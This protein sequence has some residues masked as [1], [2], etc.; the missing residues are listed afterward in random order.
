MLKLL[1]KFVIYIGIYFVSFGPGYSY[2][3][4]ELLYS[5]VYSQT[6]A[7]FVLSIYCF[8]VLCMAVNGITESFV[9]AVASESEM[10]Y[11][12]IVMLLFS[13]VYLMVAYL[14][15]QY[16]STPGLVIA[17]CLN[18]IF[19]IIFNGRYILK[20]YS[21]AK[22]KPSTISIYPHYQVLFSFIIIF[23]SGLASSNYWCNATYSIN[24]IIIFQFFPQGCIYHVLIGLAL[25]IT[26]SLQIYITEKQFIR[27]IYTIWKTK[28]Q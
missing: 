20:Q 1:L 16:F 24:D 3:L 21:Q 7:P 23:L 19:R 15:I 4:L 5:Q 8:F 14:F 12:N 28:S 13:L 27:E 17:N 2:I 25:F 18:M 26:V 22:K 9:Q 10:R 6:S 11:F